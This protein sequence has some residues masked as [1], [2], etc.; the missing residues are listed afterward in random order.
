MKYSK[1]RKLIE[2]QKELSKTIDDLY[3]L[4]VDLIEFTDGYHY[5]IMNLIKEI[6]GD[7]GYD[8]YS[9]FCYENE[10]GNKDWSKAPCYKKN[11]KGDLEKIYDTGEDRFGAY[12][13]KGNPICY[14]VYT[15]WEFLEENHLVENK[16]NKVMQE[17]EFMS[18][19]DYLGKA[20]GKK[21]GE[22]VYKNAKSLKI[23]TKTRDI[24]N[25]A[26]TG[27]VMLY[28]K[29]FLDLYFKSK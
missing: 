10:Y 26:Y 7:E 27:K 11:D 2:R 16:K 29:P 8:W 19:Y 20:A 14:S 25:S 18:L 24:S 3:K 12:D 28:P 1:F 21:L 17:Q 22:E 4:K 23:Q 15:L 9:W 5:I 6:Y 13:E